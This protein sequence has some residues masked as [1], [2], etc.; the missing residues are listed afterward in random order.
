MRQRAGIFDEL[1][2]AQRAYA[3]D[4]FHRARPLIA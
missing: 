4:P 1:V 2:R 3:A